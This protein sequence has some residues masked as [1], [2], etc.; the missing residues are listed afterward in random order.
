MLIFFKFP[1][2][3]C[4]HW[5]IFHFAFLTHMTL[6]MWVSPV[7]PQGL[8]S[9]SISF[10]NKKFNQEPFNSPDWDFKYR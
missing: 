10:F 1:F 6:S 4:F 2:K 5:Y 8:I 7:S 9:I 3:M